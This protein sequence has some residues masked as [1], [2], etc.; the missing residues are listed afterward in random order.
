MTQITNKLERQQV[1]RKHV[2][3]WTNFTTD[4]RSKR[5]KVEKQERDLTKLMKEEWK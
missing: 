1:N 4:P 5:K 3:G 2:N